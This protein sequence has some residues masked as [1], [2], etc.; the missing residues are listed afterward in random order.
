MLR[1]KALT[2]F[3]IQIPLF[4]FI[5]NYSQIMIIKTFKSNYGNPNVSDSKANIDNKYQPFIKQTN[6]QM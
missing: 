6:F 2:I 5:S 3:Y 1:C 4:I